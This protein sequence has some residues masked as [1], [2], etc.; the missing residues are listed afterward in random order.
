MYAVKTAINVSY[1]FSKLLPYEK[2]R[3]VRWRELDSHPKELRLKTREKKNLFLLYFW[4]QVNRVVH[5]VPVPY[6]Y[7]QSER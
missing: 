3:V 1:V 6:K 2:S 5:G 7:P 4:L